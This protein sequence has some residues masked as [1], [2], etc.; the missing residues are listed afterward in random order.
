MRQVL[1]YTDED[2]YWI[3]ECPSLP[4]CNSQGKT[5]QEAITNIKEAIE[6]YIE[7]LQ[8][9]GQPIPEDRFDMILMVV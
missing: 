8:E 2:G 7:V 1:L 5:K 9:K 6:L 3:A 4:G